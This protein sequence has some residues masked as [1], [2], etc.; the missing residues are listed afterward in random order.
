MEVWWLVDDDDEIDVLE[1]VDEEV[2]VVL[3]DVELSDNDVI[4]ETLDD[5]LD[6]EVEDI[7]PNDELGRLELKL[8]TDEN[9]Y[10]VIY[11]E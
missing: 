6:D 7:A 1:E 2:I 5:L 10:L 9:D 3:V 11:L 8:V 4:E